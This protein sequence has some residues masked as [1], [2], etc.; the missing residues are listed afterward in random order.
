MGKF[1]R[2]NLFRSVV[3]C[4]ILLGG[5]SLFYYLVVFLPNN[6]LIVQQQKCADEAF[7][8]F[9]DNEPNSNNTDY[10]NHWNRKQNKCFIEIQTSYISNGNP[11]NTEF[12][13]DALEGKQYGWF[14]IVRDKKLSEQ[15]PTIC[16]M[17]VD[18]N[19]SSDKTCTNETWYNSFVELYMNE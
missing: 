19:A 6:K 10:I 11:A 12:L 14:S 15:I 13:Y 8:F 9:K 2:E 18:G 4:G 3:A 1:I 5:V 17:Y 7:K 16:E